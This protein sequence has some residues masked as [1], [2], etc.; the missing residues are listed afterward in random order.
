MWLKRNHVSCMTADLYDKTVDLKLDIQDTGLP[1]GCF[2]VI[3][4]NHVL[5]HVDDFRKALKE[6]YRILRP[7]GAFICSFPMDP[8]IE[9]LD[10]DPSVQTEAERIRRFGQNDHLRVF[11]MKADQF[12]TEAGFE[13]E[14]IDGKEYQEEILPVVGPAD[15]DMNLL[16][17]CV[18]RG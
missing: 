8:K 6:M 4:C 15:Y 14:R 16:F 7:G 2:D 10:E 9:L 11:G 18:K 1:D 13:V 17:R 12:L 5:E 3:V